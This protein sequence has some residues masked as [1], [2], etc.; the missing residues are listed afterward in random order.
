MINEAFRATLLVATGGLAMYESLWG[1]GLAHAMHCSNNNT[2]SDGRCPYKAM[3]GKDY[4]WGKRDLSFG[5]SGLLFIDP[6]HRQ[7]KFQP[8]GRKGIWVGK[9]TTTPDAVRTIP[10]TW[11]PDT[12]VFVLGKVVEVAG[13]TPST[14]A[15]FIL[16]EGPHQSRGSKTVKQYIVKYNLPA[17]KCNGQGT[18]DEQIDGCDPVLEVEAVTGKVGRGNKTKY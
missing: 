13:F 8:T 9:S 15:S 18:Q 3:T 16:K 2:W 14:P 17:Y 5:Q 11:D 7:S 4:D 1:P 6:E 12:N 10:T